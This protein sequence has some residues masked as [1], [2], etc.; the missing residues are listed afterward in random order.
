MP[1]IHVTDQDW[2]RLT[3]LVTLPIAPWKPQA[4]VSLDAGL[5]RAKVVPTRAVPAHVVT[6]NSRV[7]IEFGDGRR[8]ERTLVYPWDAARRPDCLSVLAPL[9]S[10]LLGRS[11]GDA[12]PWPLPDG[13]SMQ[14]RVVDIPYQPE[15]A[16]DRLL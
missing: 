13:A 7:A 8:C 6:M 5:A 1:T 3:S 4:C 12:I 15:A 14:V 11:V 2:R 16:G 9:G 10:A